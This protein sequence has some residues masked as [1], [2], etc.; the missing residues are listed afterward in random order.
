MKGYRTSLWRKH[1]NGQAAKKRVPG[2]QEL[3]LGKIGIE[4]FDFTAA[5]HA[6]MLLH[7]GDSVWEYQKRK[8][9]WDIRR[10]RDRELVRLSGRS[11]M[12]I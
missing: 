12:F 10:V 6:D 2:N 9:G 3:L 5:G 4:S 7:P 11:I 1:R 8:S